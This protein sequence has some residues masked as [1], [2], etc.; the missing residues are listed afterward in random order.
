LVALYFTIHAL[1]KVLWLILGLGEGS[2][3]LPGYSNN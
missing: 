3:L 2:G 1:K